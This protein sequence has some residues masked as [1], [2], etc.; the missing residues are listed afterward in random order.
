[1]S[2]PAWSGIQMFCIFAPSQTAAV[3]KIQPNQRIVMQCTVLGD[4][5]GVTRIG[6]VDLGSSVGRYT[7][8]NCLIK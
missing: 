1:M 3:A 7:L 8:D 2:V 5:G 4:T 6:R